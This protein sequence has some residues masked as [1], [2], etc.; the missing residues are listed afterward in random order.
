[1]AP[2]S[3]ETP[4]IGNQSLRLGR[5]PCRRGFRD[6]VL[7]Q[8]TRRCRRIEFYLNASTSPRASASERYCIAPLMRENEPIGVI[9]IRRTVVRPFL[10]Q[11]DHATQNF[12]LSSGDRY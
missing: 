8:F 7:F 6:V 5:W 9:V 10:G 12:R 2:L 3:L 4:A 1:M 11:A